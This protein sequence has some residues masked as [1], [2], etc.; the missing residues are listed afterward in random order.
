MKD[1]EIPNDIKDFIRSI[2]LDLQ[3]HREK[4]E[5]EMDKMFQIAY[6]LYSKY[7]VDRMYDEV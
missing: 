3:T 5:E 2:T 7:K 4:T 6:K 1:K